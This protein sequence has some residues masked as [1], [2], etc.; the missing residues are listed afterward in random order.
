MAWLCVSLPEREARLIPNQGVA[1]SSP[2]GVANNI[3]Q[4]F[5]FRVPQEPGCGTPAKRQKPPEGYAASRSP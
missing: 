3:K 4:L 2:A 5:E 1:G